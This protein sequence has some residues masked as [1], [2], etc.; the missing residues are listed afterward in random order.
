MIAPTTG[1]GLISVCSMPTIK[2]QKIHPGPP[3]AGAT[4]RVYA[5]VETDG[6]RYC[7]KAVS[8]VLDVA[9]HCAAGDGG[10]IIAPCLIAPWRRTNGS[11]GLHGRRNSL[12]STPL[13]RKS[14]ASMWSSRVF[15]KIF[16]RN[17][18]DRSKDRGLGLVVSSLSPLRGRCIQN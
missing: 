14:C 12:P 18:A 16:T 10:L 15:R 9:R 13:R 5:F 11:G 4:G 2:S 17:S 7:R 8:S 3:K 1:R 6:G